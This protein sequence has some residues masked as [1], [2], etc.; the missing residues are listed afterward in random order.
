MDFFKNY[1]TVDHQQNTGW[2]Q[3]GNYASVWMK[4]MAFGSHEKIADF[5]VSAK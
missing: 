3:K 2:V 1:A 5:F 4:I